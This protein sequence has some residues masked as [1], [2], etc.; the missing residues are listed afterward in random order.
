MEYVIVEVVESSTITW[1]MKLTP[2][3]LLDLRIL[4]TWGNCTETSE[5]LLISCSFLQKDLCDIS[6]QFEG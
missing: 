6:K 5:K 3:L 2:W 4:I 1:L